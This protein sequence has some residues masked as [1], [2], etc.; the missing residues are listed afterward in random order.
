MT[1]EISITANELKKI[2]SKYYH[3]EAYSIEISQRTND[4]VIE[5]EGNV[6]MR[7]SKPPQTMI[8]IKF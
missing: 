7:I 3:V 8:T 4:S 6:V 1:G 5:Y 2:L